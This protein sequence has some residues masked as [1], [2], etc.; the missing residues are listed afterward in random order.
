MPKLT[1]LK[2]STSSVPFAIRLSTHIWAI[3]SPDGTIWNLWRIPL[4]ISSMENSPGK[5][6]NHVTTVVIVLQFFAKSKNL[7][8]TR[9]QLY[10]R[11]WPPS[12]DTQGHSPL[13]KNQITIIY[14]RQSGNYSNLTCNLVAMKV[15]FFSNNIV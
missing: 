9:F 5:E 3:N 1:Q 11:L 12:Y 15:Y 7:A 8:Q 6:S 13:T 2:I 14:S 4:F 10:L